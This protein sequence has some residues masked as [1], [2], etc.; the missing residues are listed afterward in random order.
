MNPIFRFNLQ[1]V[2]SNALK[3]V[4]HHPFHYHLLIVIVQPALHN[5]RLQTP[6]VGFEKIRQLPHQTIVAAP[7]DLLNRKLLKDSPDPKIFVCLTT[8]LV[9]TSHQQKSQIRNTHLETITE[10]LLNLHLEPIF[11]TTIVVASIPNRHPTIIVI[12]QQ[13]LATTPI[14]LIPS[15]P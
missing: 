4:V 10:I 9:K 7:M 14:H 12:H 3:F 15:I 5:R 11:M 2:T 6:Q 1:R 8:V 13:I